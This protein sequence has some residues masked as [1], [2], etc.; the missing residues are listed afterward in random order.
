[1]FGGCVVLF[2]VSRGLL[3]YRDKLMTARSAWTEFAVMLVALGLLLGSV[4]PSPYRFDLLMGGT[5]T[6]ILF[7]AKIGPASLNGLANRFNQRISRRIADRAAKR[8]PYRAAIPN[9]IPAHSRTRNAT[10]R[11]VI[12]RPCGFTMPHVKNVTAHSDHAILA[13]DPVNAQ[14]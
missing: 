1:L 5:V 7:A 10:A 3:V 6:F 14:C 9:T 11:V 13:A 8:T 2:A 12:A 4:F